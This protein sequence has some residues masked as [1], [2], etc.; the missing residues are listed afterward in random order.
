MLKAFL[1][2]VVILCIIII[3]SYFINKHR[4][5]NNHDPILY[6][7]ANVANDGGST[8][9]NFIFYKIIKY[10]N[11]NNDDVVYTIG[12]PNL[13]FDNPFYDY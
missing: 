4:I 10:K 12:S 9:Y 8:V 2:V 1:I 6:L 5:T 11:V 13:E 7:S 3:T